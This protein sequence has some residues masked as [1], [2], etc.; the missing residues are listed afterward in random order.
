[1]VKIAIVGGGFSGLCHA[2]FMKKTL[3]DAGITVF[4]ASNFGG[5]IATTR[6]ND[7]LLEPGPDAYFD[8]TGL[9]LQ[10]VAELGITDRLRTEE[11]KSAK[12]FVLKE[13]YLVKAPQSP[14]GVIFTPL[15]FFPEKIRLVL[16][17]NKRFSV[18]PT[19][20]L[21]DF[22]RNVLG[23]SAAEYLASPF[24]RG[25]YGSE[26][27]DLEFSSLFPQLFAKMQSATK[28]RHAL[29]EYLRER[30]DFWQ[31][32]LGISA[33]PGIYNFSEGLITL[34]DALKQVLE[35]RGVHL[36]KDKIIRISRDN[37]GA[38]LLASKSKTYGNFGRVI[39]CCG[40]PDAAAIFRELDKELSQQLSELKHSPMN[41][42]YTA[43]DAKDFSASGYG[44]L[45]P[46]REQYPILG[47]I[48]ASNVFSGRA[49]ENVF[50]TKTMV[51]GDS[52]LFTEEEL[53]SLVVESLSRI[54][55]RKLQ[56][57]WSRVFRHR[58][59]IPRY[60]PGYGEWKQQIAD[61]LA[62]HPGLFLRGWAFTGIGLADQAE[63]AYIFAKSFVP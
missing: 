44:F 3:P 51:S 41:V 53:A 59:G 21:F 32:E 35:Q 54:F 12:R 24:A 1:M 19:I 18:W 48:F 27:E 36:V 15:L 5:Q 56:P 43:W 26:A 39:F 10:M 61:R 40:A 7:C 58:P 45:V 38:Y 17:L 11:K 14:W 33:R 42:I 62:Q 52:E 2:W 6:H 22:A 46:R 55:R 50:L 20:S 34:V 13:G 9:F 60:A 25:I 31:K 37:S 23:A 28:L 57:L 63:S 4:E 47:T 29:K 30:R 49:P 16:A 8:R